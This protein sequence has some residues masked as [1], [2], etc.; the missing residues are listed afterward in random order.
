MAGEARRIM[1]STRAF[2]ANLSRVFPPGIDYDIDV[3]A[4]GPSQEGKQVGPS[5][6]S[7]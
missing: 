7:H 4:G 1:W 2:R 3:A 6:F 5:A